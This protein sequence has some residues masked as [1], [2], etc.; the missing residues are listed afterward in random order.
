[1]WWPLAFLC[2]VAR[3]ALLPWQRLAAF[4]GEGVWGTWVFLDG[5]LGDAGRV[6]VTA[7]LTS[8]MRTEVVFS[9]WALFFTSLSYLAVTS[10]HLF[11]VG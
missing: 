6:S 3:A 10:S 9:F 11:D 5:R 2:V 4:F 8:T 7:A 1:M